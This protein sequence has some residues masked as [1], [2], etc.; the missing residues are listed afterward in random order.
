M[1]RE[2]GMNPKKFGGLANY[3][4]E[5]W[6]RPLAEYIE[7]LYQK[8]FPDDIRSLEVKDA[9]KRERKAQNKEKTRKDKV[10]ITAEEKSWIK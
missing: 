8:R 6:K 4:K 7:H 3:K 2:L 5:Q 10:N 9:E 1:A